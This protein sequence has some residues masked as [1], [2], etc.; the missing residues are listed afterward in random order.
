MIVTAMLVVASQN[1][2][3]LKLSI[4]NRFSLNHRCLDSSFIFFLLIA[5]WEL[6]SCTLVDVLQTRTERERKGKK[7]TMTSLE[8]G[9]KQRRRRHF[10][11]RCPTT[12]HNVYDDIS[13]RI[14][15]SPHAYRRY[16]PFKLL[17]HHK[18]S[19]LNFTQFNFHFQNV[20]QQHRHWQ[21]ASRSLQSQEP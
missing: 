6:V 16:I 20:F 3:D 2:G 9:N 13:A 5:D 17:P 19:P 14:S 21:Q 11:I 10:R 12:N 18:T 7:N 15:I 4:C 1:L 8:P